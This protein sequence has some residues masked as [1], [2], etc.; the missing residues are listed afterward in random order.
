MVIAELIEGSFT[1]H[2]SQYIFAD[3]RI[4]LDT[5]LRFT[6]ITF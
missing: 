1:R 3:D 2:D 5:F 6:K 4:Y